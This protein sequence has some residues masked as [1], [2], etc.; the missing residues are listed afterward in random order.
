MKEKKSNIK[1][2]PFVLE[3]DQKA[4]INRLVGLFLIVYSILCFTSGNI[5]CALNIPF[6]FLFGSFAPIGLLVMMALGIY[7]LLFKKM[8]N[9]LKPIHYVLITMIAIFALALATA[10]EANQTMGFSDCFSKYVGK[11]GIYRWNFKFL[12]AGESN[13]IAQLGGGIIGYMLYG[14]IN[15][16]TSKNHVIT[17]VICWILFIGGIFIMAAPHI[18]RL[19]KWI[20]EKVAASKAKKEE[21]RQLEGQNPS[22]PFKGKNKQVETNSN[23]TSKDVDDLLETTEINITGE[24]FSFKKSGDMKKTRLNSMIDAFDDDIYTENYK[25]HKTNAPSTP[26]PF[27]M[28]SRLTDLY[29]DDFAEKEGRSNTHIPQTQTSFISTPEVSLKTNYDVTPKFK[30]KVEEKPSYVYN[31]E[32]VIVEQSQVTITD[33][34]VIIPQTNKP[35]EGKVYKEAPVINAHPQI[36]IFNEEPVV[37]TKEEVNVTPIKEEVEVSD[38]DDSQ[39]EIS[40]V[41]IDEVKPVVIEEKSQEEVTV[42]KEETPVI[43]EKEDVSVNEQKAPALDFNEIPYDLPP[44]Y[45]LKDANDNGA[46]A[47]NEEVARQKADILMEK[48]KELNVAATI[49]AFVV[50]PSVTRFEISLAPGVRVG[51]FTNLQEDFKLALGVNSI[52]IES[53][54][55]GKSAI[56]IEVPNQYRAMVTMKEIITKMPNKKHKLYVPVGK[57]ITGNPLS[58]PICDMPHCLISG[59]TNSGKSVCANTIIL[60]LLLNY[61]PSDVRLIMVDP[62]RVEMLFYKDIPHLLCP[63]ITESEKARVALDKLCVEMNNRFT[64]FS[65]VGVKNIA[66]Y[67]ELMLSKGKYKMP[68]II[69]VVDEFAELML[70]KNH[71]AVEERIQKLAQ[72]GRAA[73]I[74][75]ILSTQRP[76]VNVIPGTIK[77]NL[78]CRMTFRLS[79][80]VDSRTVIDVGGA[81]KL[82]NNGDMLLLT[83]DF[84]GLRRVQ[85]VYVSDKEISDVVEYCKKQA[86]PQYDPNFLDLRTEE[87]KME[88]EKLKYVLSGNN[89]N[90]SSV[91]DDMYEEVKALVIREGKASASYLQ[92]KFPIGYAKA[93]RYIDMLEEEGI[94]GPENGSKPREVLVTS[95][96]HFDE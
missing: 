18:S 75:L 80:L 51:T 43:E 39:V 96:E 52:R 63:I 60:S 41:V 38:N 6:T 79:S 57:D 66:S 25:D 2:K 22:K 21:R 65:K 73:G 16:I 50:G 28:E 27:Q 44:L 11:D 31:E 59:A 53:P 86:G 89:N 76:D 67:N 5:G 20:K 29:T 94:I 81:E 14:L 10:T 56:G 85:G 17:I 61:K 40:E 83:P 8:F 24:D 47:L 23:I 32:P 7:M 15:T 36:D 87:E 72:L 64:E 92:R 34:P 46:N 82:L 54:I 13:S 19:I 9:K 4:S 77:T 45:L 12:L 1:N 69:L 68:F 42:V 55:P 26:L 90:E 93:A 37:T 62:K 30:N 33:K 35:L 49:N 84:T 91:N 71:N 48:M 88:E 58:F 95:E 3:D 70:C 74:H 78:P